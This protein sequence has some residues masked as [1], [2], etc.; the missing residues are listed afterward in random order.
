[1]KTSW[2]WRRAL[3]SFFAKDIKLA[4]LRSIGTPD[5][6]RRVEVVLEGCEAEFSS[7]TSGMSTVLLELCGCWGDEVELVVITCED[8]SS[9][10]WEWDE[11]Y[12][13]RQEQVDAL[14]H[15]VSRLLI[16]RELERQQAASSS[17]TPV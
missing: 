14:F 16:E 9:V 12:D 3:D 10:R 2:D 15:L 13:P 11:Q 6:P 5:D 4:S 17:A 8:G 1:M 7:D